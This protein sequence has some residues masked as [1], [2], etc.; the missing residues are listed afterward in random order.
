MEQQAAH[1]EELKNFTP[2]KKREFIFQESPGK[3]KRMSQVMS[4]SPEH[5]HARQ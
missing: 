1:F 3:S 5:T 2:N 4:S